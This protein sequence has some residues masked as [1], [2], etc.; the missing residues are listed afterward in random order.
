MPDDNYSML[1]SLDFMQLAEQFAA[2]TRIKREH[3]E[4]LKAVNEALDAIESRMLAKHEASGIGSS[5]K[6]ASGGTIIVKEATGFKG[7]ILGPDGKY[8]FDM[9]EIVKWLDE[10]NLSEFARRQANYRSLTALFRER[11]EKFEPLP[12]CVEA[13][14]FK[15]VVWTK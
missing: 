2:Q 6:L 7:S 9:D 5:V 3:E 8:H 10:N 15:Q 11:L 14:G 4:E 1:D 12:D 13:K